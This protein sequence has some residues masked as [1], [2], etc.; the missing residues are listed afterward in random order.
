MRLNNLETYE[1]VYSS[2][3]FLTSYNGIG[4]VFDFP[5]IG[6][7]NFISQAIYVMK[8]QVCGYVFDR[9]EF[10]KAANFTSYRLINDHKWRK[11]IY[12]KIDYYTKHYFEA[13][14]KLIKLNLS[15]LS[16]KKI[17]QIVRKI[18]NFQHYHQVYS[19]L[20]NGIVLDGR[21]H[22]SDKIREELRRG[23]EYPKDFENYWSLLTQVTKMSL[24]QN[25]DYDMARLAK[26]VPELS[27]VV[28]QTRLKKLHSK[29]CWL[30]YNNMGPAASLNKFKREL[31]EVMQDKR[32]LVMRGQLIALKR[33]QRKLIS[34]LKLNDRLKF[35]VALAQHVIWQK[36]Y[37][38][39]VQYHGFYCYENLFLELARRKKVLDW[40]SLSFLFPWEI[41]QYIKSNRPSISELRQRREFSVFIVTKS[42]LKILAGKKA[43]VFAKKLESLEDYSD[44][45][46]VKGQC[47]YVGKV[48]G[49]IKIIQIPTDMKKMNQGDII[50]SQATSPDLLPAMKKASAIVTNTGGLICHAAITARELK[51][52]CVVGTG[53]ATLIFKDGDIVEV[54]ATKGIIKKVG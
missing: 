38:K 15:L 43:K 26:R 37:R 48:C 19:V 20:A 16:D 35:L 32:N 13:G 39:D 51:I 21:N 47:A 41:E 14:E 9:E 4:F 8:D 45:K 10:E 25:K 33:K 44:I 27:G 23:L 6:G 1:R 53:N 36:G 11:I 29:Y 50:V 2:H 49:K 7:E 24:R 54:D 31:K 22:M 3:W 46:E 12:Q 28:I 5:K 34:K 52:P 18:I 30:D 42:R 40:Q 17:I